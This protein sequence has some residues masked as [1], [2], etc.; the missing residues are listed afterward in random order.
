M[1]INN[2]WNGLKECGGFC[3]KVRSL[4][5]TLEERPA[6][7]SPV[8]LKESWTIVGQAISGGQGGEELTAILVGLTGGSTQREAFWGAIPPG[9]PLRSNWTRSMTRLRQIIHFLFFWGQEAVRRFWDEN[10]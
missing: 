3:D 7:D 1:I 8:L 2:L 6:L 9:A 5:D 4:V 10:Y